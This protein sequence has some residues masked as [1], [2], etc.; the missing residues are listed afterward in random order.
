MPQGTLKDALR[1]AADNPT[2]DFAAQLGETIASGQVDGEAQKFGIDLTP[3]KKRYGKAEEKPEQ[4]LLQKTVKNAS[5]FSTGFAKGGLQSLENLGK[6]TLEAISLGKIDTEKLGVPKE[7]FEAQGTAEKVGKFTENL[8]EFVV[9]GGAVSK[10]TKALSVIPRIVSRAVTSGG[11]AT[12][13]E[14]EVGEGTAIAAGS[15]ALLPPVAKV[16]SKLVIQPVK[17]LLGSLAS[18]FSGVSAKAI[19]TIFDNP[20]AA[21]EAVKLLEKEGSGSIVRKNA[22]TI[23]N[24]VSKIRQEARQKFGEGLEILK[25][26]DID[27][28][29]FRDSVQSVLDGFGSVKE[30]GVRQLKNVEFSDPK[31]I[32]TASSLIDK[33]SST[34]IEFNGKALRKLLDDVENS[35]YKTAT[36][37][38]RLSF[39]IFVRELSGSIKSAINNSTDKL[40]EINKAF[41]TDMQLADAIQG[42]FGKIKFKNL[43]EIRKVSEK[44]D[45]IF[46]KKGIS[47]EIIDDFLTRAGVKPSGFKT[48]EAVR[49]ISDVDSVKNTEGL[50]FAEIF[51]SITSSVLTPK[52][53]RDVSILTGMAEQTLRPVLQ[54]LTPVARG[55]FIK[56]II[57]S[58][59]E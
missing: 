2:S 11:I 17:R 18:G 22:E 10:A 29:T 8:A 37:D 26:T 41:S 32:Q 21:N 44:L 51:R 46:A 31:N 40:T 58:Q 52:A 36:S 53:V 39:N 16:G 47:P 49:Q 24:G 20:Q 7:T 19:N 5:D 50:T 27:P 30:N 35:A 45:G 13:Q 6:L 59:K 43:N 4:N 33:I 12:V 9:P 14:G 3:I 55:L 57:E 54:A 48:S 34:K 42:I 25:E 56:S 38:E 15:E 23:I 1:Y 28:K